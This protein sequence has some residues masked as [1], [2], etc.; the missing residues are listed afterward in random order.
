MRYTPW[1]IKNPA[2]PGQTDRE[3]VRLMN[4]SGERFSIR[5]TPARISPRGGES[6]FLCFG[7][8]DTC[9]GYLMTN[10]DLITLCLLLSARTRGSEIST[11]YP[12]IGWGLNFKIQEFA[13]NLRGVE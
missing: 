1:K 10:S 5:E 6:K 9:K 13:G 3:L 8:A 11:D 12:E 4:R 2:A 7:P